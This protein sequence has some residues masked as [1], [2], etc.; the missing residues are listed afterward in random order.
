MARKVFLSVL[1]TGFYDSVK[2]EISDKNDDN[3][4]CSLDT[5]FIQIATLK[6]INDCIE[7]WNENDVAYVL[8]TPKTK[9]TNWKTSE[10]RRRFNCR[11]QKEEEYIGLEEE[12]SYLQYPFKNKIE[13]EI[14]NGGNEK[15]MWDIFKVM[16]DL[17]EDDDELYV[18]LTHSFRYIPMLM[19]VFCNY[20]KFLKKIK[21]KSISYGNF[22]EAKDGI[23]PIV[24][25][26]TLSTLQDWTAASD[27]FLSTGSV[28]KLSNIYLPHIRQRLRDTKG[29]DMEAQKLRAFV[30]SLNSLVNELKLCQGKRLIEAKNIKKAKESIEAIK[31]VSTPIPF[32]PLLE[33][34]NKSLISL[35]GSDNVKNGI[36]SAKWCC[37]NG[38]YQQA[39]TLLQESIV[40]M[41]CE[42]VNLNWH[43]EVKRKYVNNAFTILGDVNI[44]NNKEEW[45]IP[46]DEEIPFEDRVKKI[47]EIINMDFTISIVKLFSTLT[48]YR[49]KIN[50]GT[51][52][53]GNQFTNVD[54]IARNIKEI[55][56]T[57]FNLTYPLA[58]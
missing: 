11:T 31:S 36:A 56:E 13:Q 10:T 23:A 39:I 7:E 6:Y 28:D 15:E 32:N 3:Y 51:M 30:T 26:T 16:Y 2:Y 4:F 49:N 52:I 34:I 46:N 35:E 5:R 54:I 42:M 38:L 45:L 43:K 47:E 25:I 24:D 17:I 1:G 27:E 8:V 57:M 18:D 55:V 50:H 29:D 58:L 22:E 48:A 14:P 41:V 21:V 19:M 53:E 20:A 37:D 33:K 9:I 44:T 12:I 40:S